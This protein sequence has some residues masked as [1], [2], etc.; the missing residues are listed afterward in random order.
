MVTVTY[1]LPLSSQV[2]GCPTMPAEVWN[3]HKILPLSA[4]TAMN[5][6]VRRPV[7]T[8]PPAVTSVPEKFGLLNGTAHFD[9]PVRGSTARR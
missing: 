8:K 9:W 2:I 6:P 1:C 4:S 5:S 7:N 3:S